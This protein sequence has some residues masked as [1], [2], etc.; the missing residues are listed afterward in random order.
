MAE[1]AKNIGD[2]NN[3]GKVDKE[4]IKVAAEKAGIA[5]DKMK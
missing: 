4:D 5:W 3:D 2:L 1:I